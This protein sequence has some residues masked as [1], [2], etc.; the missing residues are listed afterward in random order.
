M[1]YS[2][3][4]EE[5]DDRNEEGEILDGILRF[6]GTDNGDVNFFSLKAHSL[7]MT[8]QQSRTVLLYDIARLPL[9]AK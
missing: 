5:D 3:P 8:R 1:C 9:R 2:I 4:K 6:Q 7:I